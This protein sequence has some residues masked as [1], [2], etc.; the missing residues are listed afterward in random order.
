MM[1]S[2]HVCSSKLN[3]FCDISCVWLFIYL[4]FNLTICLFYSY[5][6]GRSIVNTPFYWRLVDSELYGVKSSNVAADTSSSLETNIESKTFLNRR[7][8]LE[9]Y[10]DYAN[11]IEARQG[12]RA[13]RALMK[14]VLGLFTGEK[15]GKMFRNNMDIAIKK[16]DVPIGDVIVQSA[17]CIPDEVISMY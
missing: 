9:K 4:F 6:V 17:S 7:Q 3:I 16:K 2:S 10:A 11:H 13:R 15:N 1:I 8:I 5:K 12:H 14:P